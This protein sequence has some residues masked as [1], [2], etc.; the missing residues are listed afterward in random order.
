MNIATNF[1]KVIDNLK[2]KNQMNHSS[3]NVYGRD[4]EALKFTT[5][6]DDN[7]YTV[8]SFKEIFPNWKDSGPKGD[9]LNVLTVTDKEN[10]KIAELSIT[11]GESPSFILSPQDSNLINMN[12]N[13]LTEICNNLEVLAKKDKT[14]V[15][16]N[17]HSIREDN[18]KPAATNKGSF[19]LDWK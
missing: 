2:S 14:T 4:Y 1:A 17:M 11:N 15:I 16:E 9:Y 13:K 18:N 7:N 12:M 6:I 8:A 10:N 5:T 3:E 19:N